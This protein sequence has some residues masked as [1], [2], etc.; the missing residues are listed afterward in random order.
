MRTTDWEE[1]RMEGEEETEGT[2]IE[3]LSQLEDNVAHITL[4]MYPNSPFAYAMGLVH[5]QLILS[6][7]GET[8]CLLEIEI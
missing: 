3:I 5:K 6:K 2:K 4:G 8:G 7:I 1:E